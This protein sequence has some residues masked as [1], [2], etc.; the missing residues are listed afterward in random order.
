MVSRHLQHEITVFGS[1]MNA[2][3]Y[4]PDKWAGVDVTVF[5]RLSGDSKSFI[6]STKSPRTVLKKSVRL[7]SRTPPKD[8]N[9]RA[10]LQGVKKVPGPPAV[11]RS[12]RFHADFTFSCHQGEPY[13]TNYHKKLP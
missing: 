13:Q 12:N 1:L 3:H 6:P 5:G 10:K 8:K 11:S 4:I 7:P 9:P 2:Q